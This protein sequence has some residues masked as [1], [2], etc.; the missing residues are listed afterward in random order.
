MPSLISIVVPVFNAER[1]L[2]HCVESI[3]AQTY[4]NWELILVDDG[5][6]DRSGTICDAFAKQDSRIHVIHQENGGVS[7][8][9]NTGIEYATGEWLVFI[10][11]DDSINSLTLEE[12][13]RHFEN[14]D[15]IR[16]SM[17]L[18]FSQNE[19][20][21]KDFILEDMS[22][23]D[24]LNWIVSRK[25][26]LG[27]CGGMY[28]T[29]LIQDNR[30]RF[31]PTIINGEDWL[32][33]ATIVN[34][35]SSCFFIQAP[36]YYYNRTNNQSCTYSFNYEGADSAISA[37][38]LIED[39]LQSN[40]VVKKDS[41]SKAKC[42]LVYDYVACQVKG[43]IKVSREFQKEYRRK[44]DLSFRDLVFGSSSIKMFLLLT[45]YISVIGRLVL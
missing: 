19:D 6:L 15:V 8:A 36:L 12:C 16:F 27:V 17:R 28:R 39:M 44:A 4:K 35:S 22:K 2:P 21:F 40:V 7:S 11:A 38:Y 1:Y 24:Y 42:D 31:N 9:R 37:L 34:N 43:K 25:T 10:D 41:F 26:F 20:R 30:I 14:N 5:S 32:M 13:A 18:I 45:I 3:L 23:D 29:R 33:L